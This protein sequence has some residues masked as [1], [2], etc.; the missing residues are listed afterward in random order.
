MRIP[1]PLLSRGSGEGVG[2]GDEIGG[3]CR[4]GMWGD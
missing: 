1:P 4:G 2:G 3:V